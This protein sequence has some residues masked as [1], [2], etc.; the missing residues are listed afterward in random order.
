MEN[1]QDEVLRLLKLLW[2][3]Y[4]KMEFGKLLSVLITQYDQ[5]NILFDSTTDKWISDLNRLCA[6]VINF[7]EDKK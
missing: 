3:M 5:N 7:K 1:K 4:P 2:G 6:E